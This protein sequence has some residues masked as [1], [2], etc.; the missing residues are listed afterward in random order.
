MKLR[1]GVTEAVV[2]RWANAWHRLRRGWRSRSWVGWRVAGGAGGAGRTFSVGRL[3]RVDGG[4]GG[5]GGRGAAC[6]TAV[7]SNG[8][9][10]G[11]FV[12]LCRSAGIGKR[13]DK[14]AGGAWATH[15]GVCVC[16]HAGAR[17]TDREASDADAAAGV[18]SIEVDGVGRSDDRDRGYGG[19]ERPL[20]RGQELSK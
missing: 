12:N 10:G 20:R 18:A 3:V 5:V 16:P 6:S 4:D 1:V 19:S 13:A 17:E 14:R 7:A 9:D 11:G 2:E 15:C 8:F